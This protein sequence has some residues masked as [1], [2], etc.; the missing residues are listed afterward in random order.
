M[1]KA[2]FILNQILKETHYNGMTNIIYA[3]WYIMSELYINKEKYNIAYGIINNSQIQLEKN[4]NASEYLL[5]LLK[6]NLYKIMMYNKDYNKAEICINQAI[7]IA[8]K[9]GIN[10]DFAINQENNNLTDNSITE[11]NQ[12]ENDE[13]IEGE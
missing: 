10:F 1:Q 12:S 7:Y 3:T 2:E 5:M 11:E 13:N 6:Y 4:N 8:N 9:Y